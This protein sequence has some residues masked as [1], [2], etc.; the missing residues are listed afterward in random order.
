[1][2]HK[3]KEY[4]FKVEIILIFQCTK[5]TQLSQNRQLT[6]QKIQTYR[7]S[8]RATSDCNRYS[9]SFENNNAHKS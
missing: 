3:S 1:M 8:L 5:L 9:R 7:A 4:F 6:D 2:E